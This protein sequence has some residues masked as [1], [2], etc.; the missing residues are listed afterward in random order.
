MLGVV[1]P[2][3]PRYKETPW[4][5]KYEQSWD[6]YRTLLAH[7]RSLESTHGN[8]R[9]Y[10]AFQDGSH[11]YTEGEAYDNDHLSAHGAIKLSNRIDSILSAWR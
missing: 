4:A 5:G 10:D 9:L 11:D 2:E 6:R 3:S 1:F 7:I 8:F